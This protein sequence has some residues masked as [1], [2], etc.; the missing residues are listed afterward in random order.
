MQPINVI[1][2]QGQG[3]T[4]DTVSLISA[5]NPSLVDVIT[6][7]LPEVSGINIAFHPTIMVPWGEKA[8]EPLED[9]KAGKLDPFVVVLE[10]A[11]PDESIAKKTGGYFCG[12]GDKHGKII[13]LNEVLDDLKPKAAAMVAIGTCA[14]YGGVAAGTPNPTGCRGLGDYL[15]KSYKS[16]LGLPVI[17]VPGCPTPGET[18]LKF[19]ANLV[20]VARGAAAVPALDEFNRPKYLYGELAHHVCPRAGFLA[21]GKFS[22]HYGE[23]YCMGLLGCKGPIVHCSVP[24]T[25]FAN[26]KGGC[27]STGSPCIGCTEPA[28]PDPPMSPFL[29]KSPI[30]SWV[31]EG[32][33]DN[34]GKVKATLHRFHKRSL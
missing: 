5:S 15:G 25:G 30:K 23:P 19:L 3:C 20:L 16:T 2:L 8:L 11:V 12:I 29:Q 10:G 28:F 7:V 21:E 4:G 6:G 9:A 31:V 27:P 34:I 24:R 18:T 1:W 26:G 14:A 22:H 17:N 33:L 13:T 32:I